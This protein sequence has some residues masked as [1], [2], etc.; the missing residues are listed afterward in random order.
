M[1]VNLRESPEI[2]CILGVNLRESP[3]I[4]CILG[5]YLRERLKIHCILGVNPRE[6]SFPRVEQ[7]RNNSL[8]VFRFPM[9]DNAGYTPPSVYPAF[10]IPASTL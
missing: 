2:H 10:V 7:R 3:E 6:R 9:N 4:H 1:G 8:F 5:S